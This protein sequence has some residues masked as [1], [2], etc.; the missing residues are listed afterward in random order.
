MHIFKFVVLFFK[1]MA[2][3][4]QWYGVATPVPLHLDLPKAMLTGARNHDIQIYIQSRMD[5][6]WLRM[7][8][9][10]KLLY[11]GSTFLVW[12]CAVP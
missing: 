10:W 9:P 2:I 8:L 5:A 4:T 1:D 11:M 6:G 3:A 7:V 12:D